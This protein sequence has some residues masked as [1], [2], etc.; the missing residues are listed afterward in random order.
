MASACAGDR[1]AVTSSSKAASS[2]AESDQRSSISG[3]SLLRS[4]PSS[5]ERKSGSRACIHCRLPR[6]VLIS[7]LWARYWNGCARSQLPSVF[8]EKRE[9]TSAIELSSSGSRRSAK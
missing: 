8:V 5:A 2:A 7:P 4:S 3:N 6:I 9:C 1:P